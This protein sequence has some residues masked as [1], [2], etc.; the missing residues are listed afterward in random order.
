MGIMRPGWTPE[1]LERAARG[2]LGFTPQQSEEMRAAVARRL[3]QPQAVS[4]LASPGR[5]EKGQA[6]NPQA[7]N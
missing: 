5:F 3:A 4:E 1:E 6:R 7:K 2:Q